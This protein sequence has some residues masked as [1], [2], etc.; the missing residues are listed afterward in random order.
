MNVDDIDL[1]DPALFTTSRAIEVFATLRRKSPVHR[2][3]APDGGTGF[4]VVSRY[5]DVV[6]VLRTPEIFSSE[7][8]NIL[9]T[10][11]R[12]D[13]TAGVM[14]FTTDPPVHRRL[15]SMMTPGLTPRAVETIKPMVGRIINQIVSE[16]AVGEPFDFMEKIAGDLPIAV[17]CGLLGV[18]E[19]DWQYLIGQIHISHGVK[20]ENLVVPTSSRK[21]YSTANLTLLGYFM[22]LVAARRKEPADDLVSVMAKGRPDG[23]SL[24]DEEIAVNCFAMTLGG[25]Q[26]D[27]NAMGGGVL[28]LMEHPD[29]F[30]HLVRDRSI[31]PTAVEEILRWSTPTLNLARVALTSTEIAGVPIAEG[32]HVSAWLYSANRDETVFD[33][34]HEFDL[35]RQPNRHLSFGSSTHYCVGANVARLEMTTLLS[36]ILDRG[37]VPEKAGEPTPIASYFQQGLKHLPVQF[38]RRAVAP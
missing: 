11:A 30:E 17:S 9:P 12:R 10:R 4:W 14:T 31:M 18:P 35:T 6:S 7:Y 8:G 33:N 27:R 1:A 26:A 21:G 32:D 29:Q 23:E 5:D 13:P 22:D 24:T 28:A 19:S 2:Y 3:E 38:E 20:D 37:L 16:V 15:R 36:A 25:F 34:P